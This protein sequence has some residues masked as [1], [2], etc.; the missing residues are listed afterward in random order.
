MVDYSLDGLF[1]DPPPVLPACLPPLPPS[2]LS[3]LSHAT[4]SHPLSHSLS[5]F[6]S[7]SPD[8]SEDF[9]SFFLPFYPI[10]CSSHGTYQKQN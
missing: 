4:H 9:L 2:T 3:L 5:W 10:L 7:Y 8:H 1:Q 6:L